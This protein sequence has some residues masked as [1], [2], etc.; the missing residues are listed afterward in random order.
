MSK[1]VL[2]LDYK[3]E[4]DFLLFGIFSH[5]RE[6]QVCH[7]INQ[8]LE[9]NMERQDDFKLPLE[10]KGST[11]IFSVFQFLSENEEEYFLI[12]NK[13]MN[14]HYIPSHKHVDYF[15]MIR[16]HNRYTEPDLI[17]KKTK[18]IKHVSSVIQLEPKTL[19]SAENF[20]YIEYIDLK[21]KREKEEKEVLSKL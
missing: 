3:E 11:G 6:Y 5:Q 16:N 17:I 1:K 8:M 19:K 15:M 14:A 20:F 7:E 2:T 4:F 18:S 21:S 12:S 10:K 13:G 9:M